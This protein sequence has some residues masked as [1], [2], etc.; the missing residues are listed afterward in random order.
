MKC[1]TCGSEYRITL[2]KGKHIVFNA[3]LMSSMEQY[4]LVRAIKEKRA[5]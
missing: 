3:R 5:S 1:Y 4:G 2:V